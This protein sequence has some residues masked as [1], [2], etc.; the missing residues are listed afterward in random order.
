MSLSD[1]LWVAPR[2]L[3]P[4]PR[5]LPFSGAATQEGLPGSL[6]DLSPRA[7]P[8]HPGE[9]GQV[10]TPYFPAGVRLPPHGGTGHSLLANEAESDSLTLRLTGLPL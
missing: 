4:A 7:A 3:I 9:S 5:W 10:L 1:S 6:T 2:L 8:N